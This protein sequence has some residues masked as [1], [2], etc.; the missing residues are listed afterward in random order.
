MFFAHQLTGLMLGTSFIP[1]K[2]SGTKKNLFDNCI[3]I[4]DKTVYLYH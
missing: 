2:L 4:D 3:V 1:P